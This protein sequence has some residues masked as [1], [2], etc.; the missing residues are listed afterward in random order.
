MSN[1]LLTFVPRDRTY[2]PTPAAREQAV[3]LLRSFAPAGDDVA[4]TATEE[5]RF[6]DC[7]GNWSGVRC[8]ACGRDAE[9]W[10]FDAVSEA[11][12]RS[13]FRELSLA[14]PCCGAGVSLDA[15]DFGWP[16]AFARYDLTARNPWLESEV[17]PEPQLRE[18]EE[19]VGCPLRVIWRRY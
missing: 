16:V 12:E 3:R 10:F 4:D 2:V 18:L 1:A 15:L 19:A 9:P 11:Y 17:F 5:I 13:G 14:A 6:I 8:P 7:R